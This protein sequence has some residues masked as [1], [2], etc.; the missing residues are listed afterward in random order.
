MTLK[1]AVGSEI[2]AALWFYV[3]LNEPSCPVKDEYKGKLWQIL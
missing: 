3:N 2:P 1:A